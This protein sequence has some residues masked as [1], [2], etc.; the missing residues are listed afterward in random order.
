VIKESDEELMLRYASHDDA[1]AFEELYRRYSARVFSYLIKN[2]W[3]SKDAEEIHQSVF[4]KMHQRKLSYDPKYPFS[5]WLFTMVKTT[6]IDDFRKTKSRSNILK[7]S[8]NNEMGEDEENASPPDLS[9][10]DHLDESQKKLL[11]LRYL[12]EWSFEEMAKEFKVNTATIRKRISR[13]L[14][15]L[16]GAT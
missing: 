2:C 7:R 14:K 12:E 8:E 15:Q 3:D 11:E 9:L 1:A 10:T 6:M 5:A 13:L 4:L 16:R